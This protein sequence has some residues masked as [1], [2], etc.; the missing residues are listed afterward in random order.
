MNKIY[1]AASKQEAKF[2]SFRKIGRKTKTDF[3]FSIKGKPFRVQSSP[4]S[5]TQQCDNE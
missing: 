5:K 2:V 1:L 4:I 3:S